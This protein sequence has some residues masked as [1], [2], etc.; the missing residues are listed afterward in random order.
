MIYENMDMHILTILK[1]LSKHS[2]R[3][4]IHYNTERDQFYLD[5]ETQAKSDLHLYDDGILRGRY[6][7][8]T[9][10]DFYS[11]L[12]DTVTTLCREF[13]YAL[14]GRDYYQ[15]AWAELCKSKNIQLNIKNL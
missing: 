5:L 7:Y 4:S 11:D 2:I 13:N 12:E 9:E 10:I 14:H 8:E 15:S 3:T 1:E 6:D